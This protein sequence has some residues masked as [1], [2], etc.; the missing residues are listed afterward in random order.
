MII[1][2]LLLWN[3]IYIQYACLVLWNFLQNL[4]FFFYAPRILADY[5]AL[6]V[7]RAG[8]GNPLYAEDTP[9][10]EFLIWCA[11]IQEFLIRCTPIQEFEFTDSVL[12]FVRGVIW[13]QEGYYCYIISQMN[14]FII[15]KILPRKC[16]PLLT[17][18]RHLWQLHLVVLKFIQ[19]NDTSRWR[20]FYCV[21]KL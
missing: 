2:Y 10:Q 8:G 13:H 1:S 21:R 20:S 3:Y 5:P 7:N 14:T 17:A 9:N 6:S 16:L 12:V 4:A 15:N 11:P 19:R 18:C